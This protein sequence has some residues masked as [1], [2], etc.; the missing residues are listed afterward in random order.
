MK[1][2]TSFVL[3][4]GLLPIASTSPAADPD[5]AT[6]T[7]LYRV[8]Y[9]GKDVGTSEFRVRYIAEHDVYEFSSRTLAKG[10][11]KLVSPNP[12]IERSEFRATRNGI[13]PLKFWYEDGSRKGEDNLEIVFDWE[14]QV[15]MV[16]SSAGNR[17]IPLQSG[18]LDRGSLQV[19]LMRDLATTGQPGRYLL[20]DEDS[21]RGYEYRDNGTA[22]TTTGFGALA[23]RSLMQQREGSS[24]STW[25]WLA[26]ELRF[27]PAR[28]EQRRDGE[29]Y[30]AFSLLSV[31]GLT[32]EK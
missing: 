8:E 1:P 28:I 2:H 17:E 11:L 24:R 9:K 3:L 21:I 18:A 23:T 22:T 30:T 15:A 6:Y 14:R 19:A 29:L 27:L 26:P 7:A 5:V 13:V 10:L 32:A 4:L 16:S 20:T 25:L 12:V 31:S